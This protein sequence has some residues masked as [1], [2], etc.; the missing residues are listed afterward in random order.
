MEA[1][2]TIGWHTFDQSLLKA[3]DDGR[4]SEE[5]A[6]TYCTNKNKMHRDLD[7]AKK[8]RGAIN[9]DAP[10]GL[11]LNIPKPIEAILQEQNAQTMVPEH[12]GK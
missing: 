10:S 6:L 9:L 11:K 5:V 8:R 3:F 12:A 2:S 4:V 7:L 1:G